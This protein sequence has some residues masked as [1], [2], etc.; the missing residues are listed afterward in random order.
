MVL[1]RLEWYVFYFSDTV[2]GRVATDNHSICCYCY[3]DVDRI[4][5]EAAD[6]CVGFL[7][8]YGD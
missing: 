7:Q 5:I 6:G 2:E 8:A 3:T 4:E 1:E